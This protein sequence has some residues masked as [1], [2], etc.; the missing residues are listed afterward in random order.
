LAWVTFAA[1]GV[2]PWVWVP[3]ACAIALSAVFI[4]PRIARE[5]SARTLDAALALSGGAILLQIVPLP[6]SVL[7]AID[8][9]ALTVRA[10]LWLA[11]PTPASTRGQLP[12]SIVP[13]DTLEAAGIFASAVLLFWTCR[14]I[15]EAGGAGRIVR[16]IAVIGLAGSIAAIVQRAQ[17]H[18]L[19]Y[20]IWRPLDAGARPYGPFVNRNHFATWVVMAS[21][22]VFGYLLARTPPHS[23]SHLFSQRVVKALKQLGSLRIWLVSSVCVMTLA[24][25]L[26]ASRSG[27]IALMCAIVA[28]L[29]LGRETTGPAIRRWTLVQGALL[30]LVAVSFANFD[31][32]AARLDETLKPSEAARGRS[33]IWIDAVRVIRDFPITGTGAGTFGT[34][35]AVYQ[36]AEPGYSIGNAHNHYLQLAAEGGLLVGVPATFAMGA[37]IAL[38]TRR[39]KEDGGRDYLVRAGAV[40]GIAAVMVQ[41]FWETGLRMPANAMLLAVLAAIATHSDNQSC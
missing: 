24:L 12:L 35:I 14:H 25:L 7:H 33:A 23:P 36:T 32:L 4:R 5:P 6:I 34:S 10:S 16:A 9:H 27:L 37:L 13:A 39:L 1:G 17:S 19:L 41:S 20:G 30:V 18:D 31:A 26:S 21:P 29:A 38:F 8:P 28:S 22:L 11:A 40:A 15:C 2:Y 3:A